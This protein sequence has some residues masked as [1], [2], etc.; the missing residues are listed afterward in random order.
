MASTPASAPS[1]PAPPSVSSFGRVF[2]ALVNPKPTFESIAQ[3][4]SW[5]LPM[6]LVLLCSIVIIA[7]I[8]QR[9]GWHAVV[10]KQI[11]N[12]ARAQKQMEQMPAEQRQR[13]IDQQTKFASVV[14]YVSVVIATILGE[15][16]VAALLLAVFNL[17]SGSKIGFSTS[18]GIVAHSWMPYFIGG[19]LSIIVLYIKDPSTVDVQ[20][21]VATNPGALLSSDSPKW[22]VSLLTSLDLLTFWVIALQAIGFSATNP[23]KISFGKAFGSI[24]AVWFV[25]VLIKMGLAAAFS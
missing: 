13:I 19:I 16:V 21:I 6:L 11:A 20:N 2:G 22:L 15:V 10:E 23:K 4:P 24:F 9:I 5:V 3:R 14:G 8:G 1:Q 17:M 25:Y 7:V 18:L 12:S